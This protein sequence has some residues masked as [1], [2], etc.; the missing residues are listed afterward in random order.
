MDKSKLPGLTKKSSE[1]PWTPTNERKRLRE[2]AGTTGTIPS[3]NVVPFPFSVAVPIK[4][5]AK[6]LKSWKEPADKISSK[7]YREGKYPGTDK[8]GT[9]KLRFKWKPNTKGK[10][11]ESEC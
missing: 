5:K 9:K 1:T 6:Q 4:T 8:P 10:D 2:R 11:E 3:R 7:S